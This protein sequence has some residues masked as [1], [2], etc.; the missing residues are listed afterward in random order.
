M[1]RWAPILLGAV[2]ALYGAPAD[3]Q[4]TCARHDDQ[5]AQLAE[6][7]G[8]TRIGFG[9]SGPTAII[10]VWANVETGTWSI[11]VV[12]PNGVSCLKAAGDGWETDPPVVPG[13]PA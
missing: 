3:A 2:I 4:R 12:Y 11:L 10:E 5:T 8:E 1:T 9:V 6:K 7:Y 13:D